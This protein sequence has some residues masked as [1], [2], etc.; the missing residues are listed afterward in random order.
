MNTWWLAHASAGEIEMNNAPAIGCI[1]PVFRVSNLARSIEFYREQ[2]GFD[3]DF[4]Y[5]N[6]QLYHWIRST[7]RP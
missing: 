4:S 3:F 6:F 7:E 2:L 5:E 1:A